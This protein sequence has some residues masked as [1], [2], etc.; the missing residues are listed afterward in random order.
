MHQDGGFFITCLENKWIHL[1]MAV[2][3]ELIVFNLGGED[4]ESTITSA[5]FCLHGQHP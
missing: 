5:E 4:I 2:T 3:L 1:L